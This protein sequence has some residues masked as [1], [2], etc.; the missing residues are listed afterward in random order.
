VSV[1]C[2]ACG[3]PAAEGARFCAGCGAALAPP[4]AACGAA[5]P[6]G[7]RFCPTCG[8]PTEGRA[9]R[10]ERKVVTILFA[11]V[12]GSTGLG[13]R[14]D[15]ER[16]KS[17]MAGWF[18]AM[19]EEI[20]AHGGTVEKFIGDAVMAAF[21]VPVAHE[22]DP[23]RAARAALAMRARLPALNEA[24]G[25]DPEA[26]IEARIGVNTGEVVAAP[27]AAPGEAMATGDAVNVAARLEAAAAPG[28]ILLAERT[29]RACRGLML[30]EVAPLALRGREA[31]V[32]AFALEGLGSAPSRGVQ[33]LR[34]P[35][36]GR[37]RE[38]DLLRA[39]YARAA[40]ER[41]PH[42][43]TLYGEPGVGKSRLVRELLDRLEGAEPA[44]L[45]LR[46]R[47]LPYGEGVT[48]WPLAEILK[49]LAGVRD[50]D[51]ADLVRERV[52]AV[53][54]RLPPGVAAE[55]ERMA[56]ALAYTLG[57]EDP[58]A[59]VSALPPRQVRVETQQAWRALLSSL[60]AERP[61]VA[62]V[63]DIHWADPALLDLLEDIA[64]RVDG[65]LLLL[66]PSRPELTSRRP[67]WGGGRRRFSS[68][69]LE[70]L[71]PEEAERLVGLLL[72]IDDLPDSLRRRI[73]E[74][75]EGNPFFLEE[76]LRRLI[77]EGRLV[78]DG[79]RWRAT[80]RARDV[81]IPDTIQAVLAARIDLLDPLD[82]RVLQGAAVVG[83]IFWSG[84]ILELDGLAPDD[85]DA[86][87]ERLEERELVLERL[88]A[89]F[90]GERELI[91][92]HVLTREVAYEGLPLRERAL[93]HPR[94]AAWIERA[95]GDRARELAETIANHYAQAWR[96][97]AGDP[98]WAPAAVEDLRARALRHMLVAA[99]DALATFALEKAGALAGLA[100]ELARESLERATA[101][102]LAGT[103][104]GLDYR[105]DDAWALLREATDLH[106]ASAPDE[107]DAIARLC[108]LALEVPTRWTGTMSRIPTAE[109]AT[110][111]LELGLSS[112]GER[113]G[114]ARLRLL[115]AQAFWSH[116]WPSDERVSPDDA[117]R[118]GREAAA[119]ALR[120]ERPELAEVA[121]DAVQNTAQ[122]RGD[123]RAAERIVEQRLA[124]LPRI[125]DPFETGDALA[126][127]SWN[128][129]F[130]GD[131]A[132]AVDLGTRAYRV[133]EFDNPGVA[134]HGLAWAAAAKLP[135]GE[136]DEIEADLEAARTLMG[137][138]RDRPVAGFSHLWAVAALVREL[139]GQ[140]AAADG[141]LAVLD[142]LGEGRDQ[143]IH[144]LLQWIAPILLRR[145]EV[146]AAEARLGAA[147][148]D[149]S[150][151]Q[152]R[153][154]LLGVRCELIAETGR[155]DR[156]P[157]AVA[158]T[159]AAAEAGGLD[160]VAPAADRLEGRAALA[161]GRPAEAAAALARAAEAYDR[162]GAA[163]EA[164][165]TR[166]PL[167]EA[168]LAGG[169]AARSREAAAAALAVAERVGAPREAA[170][171]RAVL[172]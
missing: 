17:V 157:E 66:C 172:P 111:Y 3:L 56:A 100:I 23:E 169:E 118:A 48:Y 102:E 83:R 124:L 94:V 145:G 8:A 41:R 58:A 97:A 10:E 42:L 116:A 151:R 11:D 33:G 45:I 168:L 38:L 166:I 161:A 1:T 79:E 82:K 49:A 39:L 125:R 20:E 107:R 53:V 163:W 165:V 167:A 26:A 37:A 143:P 141:L 24:L 92:K 138:R 73:L 44:P 130:R 114:E 85:L 156:A 35:M 146:D 43:C 104:A 70:P 91:F 144:R 30:R 88:G 59:P 120:M 170:A 46:G 105:G 158:E 110:G 60:G 14:M 75:G 148:E 140:R 80:S 52:R 32:R 106:A 22:D 21:G 67:G 108:G 86:A 15:A 126:C 142:R 147:I 12:A 99:R 55:P 101:L 95:A 18:A 132:A 29:A 74:R 154:A 129:V 113:D 9:P 133:L 171:A 115:V 36:V 123:Y 47:C 13:E 78:R 68:L 131:Y 137:E 69:V 81:E 76:I 134:V 27:G 19:R 121:L 109:E 28:Q 117:D 77:D 98:R 57:V 150:A 84:S 139:R 65:A 40:S 103:V 155:W 64:Q 127:A 2:V 119:I 62:V 153:G 63:E 128:A 50:S 61:V 16:L 93:A 6:E 87:L 34:A 112:V 152:F 164:A 135:R 4:C 89:A 149:E 160:A 25:L 159:R 72:D 7:A 54:D 71:G 96:I 5:L 90:A 51:P 31:P 162:L 122:T 136:W